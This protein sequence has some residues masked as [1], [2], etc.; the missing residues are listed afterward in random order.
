MS[1]DR[2]LAMTLIH[3]RLRRLE[4]T[5]YRKD[6]FTVEEEVAGTLSPR[7][8]CRPPAR[9]T[10]SYYISMSAAPPRA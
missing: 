4:E 8:A 6:R 9:Y 3:K 7:I 10:L 5:R 2:R 1:R